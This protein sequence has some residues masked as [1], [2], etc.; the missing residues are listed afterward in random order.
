MM[1]ERLNP[2]PRVTKRKKPLTTSRT[3]AGISGLLALRVVT[4]SEVIGAAV[5][6]KGSLLNAIVRSSYQVWEARA[7]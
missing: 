2:L 4:L 6:N 3:R 7:N 1:E 5:D